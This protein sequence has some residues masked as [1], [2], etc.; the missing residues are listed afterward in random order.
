MSATTITYVRL[1]HR[2]GDEFAGGQD[3]YRWH[4]WVA[5]ERRLIVLLEGADAAETGLAQE[6]LDA[7]MLRALERC[8]AD[9][10]LDGLG[11]CAAPVR[12]EAGHFR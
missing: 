2:A 1:V 12:L 5:G 8:V 9:V 11:T 6:E 7:G 4:V 10:G 3:A